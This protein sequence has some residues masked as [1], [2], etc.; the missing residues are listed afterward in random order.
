VQSGIMLTLEGP[1]GPSS[2]E[3]SV[4]ECIDLADAV[5]SSVSS[6]LLNGE[7]DAVIPAGVTQAVESR[8]L[9]EIL[10]MRF[11]AG[12][13]VA[14]WIPAA[15]QAGRS[16]SLAAAAH[17]LTTLPGGEAEELSRNAA[18]LAALRD[19][20]SASPDDAVSSAGRLL[21]R[22]AA[23]AAAAVRHRV[24]FERAV[25]E[26]R[27]E[28]MKQLAY[29]AGHEI[30]N[31]LANIA[32]R[33]QSLLPGERD[34]E[35]RRRLAAIIDQAFRARDMIGGLMLFARPPKPVRREVSAQSIV[36]AAVEAVEAAARARAVRIV[37]DAPGR[38]IVGDWDSSQLEEAVRAVLLNAIEAGRGGGEVRVCVGLDGG[39]PAAKDAGSLAAKDAGS[40]AAK[41]AGSPATCRVQIDDDGPGM[42]RETLARVFDPFFSGREA[43]RGI[44]L[45]LSKV[46]RLVE[47]NGGRTTI[48][49]RYGV[50]TTVS[51]QLPVSLPVSREA[52]P[53]LGRKADASFPS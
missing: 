7:T 31:P 1:G 19:S 4:A 2:V 24:A 12:S 47:I 15:T 43:G 11:P 42:D 37:L 46:W 25:V 21:M 34:P 26:A 35:R 28:S 41:D 33:A 5:A 32:T 50:G 16:G 38:E 10:L 14:R 17:G 52:G 39:S 29:G 51:I 27:I 6:A 3:L 48:E 49:S 30:N 53:H 9:D 44:G 20:L 18:M 22:F 45:G 23:L 13:P 36:A 40:L 8:P